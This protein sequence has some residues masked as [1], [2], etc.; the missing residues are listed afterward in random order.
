MGIDIDQVILRVI[1]FLHGVFHGPGTSA[2]FRMGRGDM[3]RV[4]GGAVAA[5]LAV[6]P[7][8]AF[9]RVAVFLQDE[10]RSAFSH[11]ETAPAFIKRKGGFIRI[12]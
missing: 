7:G 1:R 9:F 2:G 8:P 3:I 10:R 6:D 5:Y 4:T 11:D 12:L